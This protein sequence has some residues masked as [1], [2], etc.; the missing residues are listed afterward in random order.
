MQNQTM[1]NW[2]LLI[3]DD[4]STDGTQSKLAS[5]AASDERINVVC[6]AQ[7]QGAAYARNNALDRA[8]GQ[9]IAFLDSDDL[10]FPEKLELQKQFMDSGI[11]F[12]FAPYEIIDEEGTPTGQRV[13][14]RAPEDVSYLDMLKKQATM[15]CLTVAVRRTAIGSTRMPAIRQGQDY[16]LWLKLLQ[17]VP[18]AY[19]MDRVLARYRVVSGSISSNKLRKASRQWQIYRDLEQ[20]PLLN[21]AY[22]FVYYVR[23]ALFRR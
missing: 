13:D 20:L 2:E 17:Q 16:A 4:A 23:N 21:S 3:C 10:W 1:E 18:K 14:C 7:N 19:R 9:Y 6:S 5:L 12:S 15:G 22:Y 8:R 11:D